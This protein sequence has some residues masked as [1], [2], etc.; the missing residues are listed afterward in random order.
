MEEIARVAGVGVGT[1]YRRYPGKE[2]LLTELV[3]E[4]CELHLV[5]L[6]ATLGRPE[7]PDVLLCEVIKLHLRMGEE[8]AM[9][10]DMLAPAGPDVD[11]E[12]CPRTKAYLRE[13]AL[14]VGLIEVGMDAGTFRKGDPLP[15]AAAIMEL[16]HWQA[17]TRL[18]RSLGLSSGEAADHLTRLVLG[19]LRASD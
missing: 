2:L 5:Q 13:R 3:Q 16:L 1:I 14:L 12:I 19:G 17:C 9:L 18:K 6:E 7:Q 15:M 11:T 10:L 4:T 8:H